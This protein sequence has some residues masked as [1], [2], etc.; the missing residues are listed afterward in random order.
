MKKAFVS[1]SGGKDSVLALYRAI[2]T[3]DVPY[4]LNMLSE[5]GLNSRSHGLS[6][7]LLKVQAI[8]MGKVIIQR[9]STWKGYEEAFKKAV[10]ELKGKGITA[11]VFGDIELQEH[12]DWIERVCGDLDIEPI[13]PLWGAER[14]EL[15]NE[16]ISAG[17]RAIVVSTRA[18]ILGEEWLGR[19]IDWGFVK[20]MKDLGDVDLCGELGEYHTFV[21]DGP[22]FRH[23][24]GFRLGAPRLSGQHWFLE[25]SH[26]EH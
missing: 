21:F 13:F 8:A 1:W 25:I 19:E 4:L 7:K 26:E 3:V 15:I 23:P 6:A 22:L 12:R 5:D 17:F 24:V 16:F 14:E 2:R 18:E 11:E 20:D 9:P 10:L